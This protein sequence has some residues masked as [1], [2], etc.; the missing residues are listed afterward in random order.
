METN[1]SKSSPIFIA[2]AATFLVTA[3]ISG[4]V[5]F[6][7]QEQNKN[8]TIESTKALYNNDISKLESQIE[9]LSSEIVDLTS[10]VDEQEKPVEENEDTPENESSALVVTPSNINF[11]KTGNLVA[12]PKLLYEE[13]GS[14]A[15]S[16]DLVYRNSTICIDGLAVCNPSSLSVGTRIYVAGEKNGSTVTVYYMQVQH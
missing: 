7:I 10:K 6:M 13:T 16:V 12:G 15:L 1:S 11:I 2:I 9:E 14:P 8:T 5:V 4:L 3:L